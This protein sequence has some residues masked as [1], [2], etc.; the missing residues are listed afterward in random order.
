MADERRRRDRLQRREPA[1]RRV[2]QANRL[3]YL[4][5]PEDKDADP[6]PPDELRTSNP[7]AVGDVV[8]TPP[9]LSADRSMLRFVWR[10][11]A[12]SPA[13]EPF[14]ARLTVVPASLNPE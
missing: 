13:E 4:V 5:E 12:R 9:V 14:T 1:W 6:R 11:T 7:C 2:E 8:V 10:I 3:R